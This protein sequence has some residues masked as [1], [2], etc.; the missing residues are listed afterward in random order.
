MQQNKKEIT[1]EQRKQGLREYGLAM[2]FVLP[3]VIFFV[4]F[5]LVPLLMG[6]VLSFFGYNPNS[7]EQMQFGAI[8]N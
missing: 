8:R 1:A 7:P 6:V 5:T 2:V 4:L 3:F